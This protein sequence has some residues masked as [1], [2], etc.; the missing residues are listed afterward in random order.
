MGL[1]KCGTFICHVI[2]WS[3]FAL[4]LLYLI[5]YFAPNQIIL[6]KA[7]YKSGYSSRKGSL[8]EILKSYHEV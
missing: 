1:F 3:S 8:K 6:F 2:C 7:M 5:C 4:A